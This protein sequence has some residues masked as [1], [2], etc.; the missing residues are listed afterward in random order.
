MVG[1]V[2]TDVGSQGIG[3]SAYVALA[4]NLR[5]SLLNAHSEWRPSH[6]I[7]EAD[8]IARE[9]RQPKIVNQQG[10]FRSSPQVGDVL[11]SRPTARADVY[12]IS[13]FPAASHLTA[14]RHSEALD[15]ARVLARELNVDAW[16]TFNHTHYARVASFR[17]QSAH[18][19]R[20]D[21]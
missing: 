5:L 17:E 10:R 2:K 16:F 15:E 9:D 21:R 3:I 12:T 8:G 20:R 11:A 18:R 6:M 4:P 14:T 7:T 13:I 19:G 1:G